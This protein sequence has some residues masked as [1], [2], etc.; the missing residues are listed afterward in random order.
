V[1]DLQRRICPV[2]DPRS[3]ASSGT[4]HFPSGVQAP[5][6]TPPFVL[7]DFSLTNTPTPDGT[8][9]DW[10]ASSL[11]STYAYLHGTA[12]DF[13]RIPEAPLPCRGGGP[14]CWRGPPVL[15]IQGQPDV[16]SVLQGCSLSTLEQRWC[17]RSCSIRT[18]STCSGRSPM[19]HRR[20]LGLDRCSRSGCRPARGDD[21]AKCLV[22]R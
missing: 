14:R 16:R 20:S 10:I 21:A 5:A 4:R 3:A 15:G 12:A 6:D 17:V 11:S 2:W 9:I 8:S 1:T 7:P 22:W 18:A 13:W 19:L